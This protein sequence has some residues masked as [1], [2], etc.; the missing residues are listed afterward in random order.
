MSDIGN[1]D[2]EILLLES[3]K[4]AQKIKKQKRT[5]HSMEEL[6]IVALMDAFTIIL[7]FLIKSYTADPTSITM[8]QGLVLPKSTS[9]QQLVDAVRV[10]VTQQSIIVNDAV[11]AQM[12]PGGVIEPGELQNQN[13]IPKL[14]DALKAQAEHHQMIHNLNQKVKEFEGLLLV[15]ADKHTQFQSLT[16]VLYSSG[17]AGFGKYKFAVLKNE[18]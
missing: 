11:V 6:N 8:R 1:Q 4:K 9:Q 2:D 13:F 14:H 15:V 16:S 3:R 12:A 10:V 17:Q 7:V 5:L 18:Q